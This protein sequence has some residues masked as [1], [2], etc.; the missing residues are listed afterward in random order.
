VRKGGGTECKEYGGGVK[1]NGKSR[2][3]QEVLKRTNCI[4]SIDRIRTA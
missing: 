3:E 2:R 1:G 4:L